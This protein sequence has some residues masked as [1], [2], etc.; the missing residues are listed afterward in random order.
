MTKVRTVCI[1]TLTG[2]QNEI[3]MTD[4]KKPGYDEWTDYGKGIWRLIS[5]L[6]DQGFEIIL[7]L[8]EPGTGK[9]S[10]MRTLLPDTNIWFNA[11]NK[12]PVWTGGRKEYGTKTNPRMPYHLVP[13][14]YSEIINHI[15]EGLDKGMFEERRFAILTAHIEDYNSGNIYKK[16]LK[17]LG[18]VATNMQLEG[19]LETVLYAEVQKEGSENKYVLCTQNDGFNTARSPMEL[20]D[21]I[22]END[23][24]FV[25]NRLLEY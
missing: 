24:N 21:P 25:I 19:R 10:G 2:I 8:G 17:T 1:D 23:Y 14:K 5:S 16:R 9:S 12:N 4:S 15:Q 22:I 20:F 3:Y 7:I 13:K 6:Q 11:D 18:K